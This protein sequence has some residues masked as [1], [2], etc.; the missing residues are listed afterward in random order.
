MVMRAWMVMVVVCWSGM[1]WAAEPLNSLLPHDTLGFVEFDPT[2][3]PAAGPMRGGSL[4]DLGVETMSSLGVMHGEAATITN[5]LRLAG[6]LGQKRSCVAWLGADFDLDYQTGALA[7]HEPQVVWVIDVGGRPQTVLGL[8]N[9]LL[10]DESSPETARQEIVTIRDR[11]VVSFYDTRWSSWVRLHW[12]LDGN[13]FVITLGEGAMEKYLAPR[14]AEKPS[15]LATFA[16][17]DADRPAGDQLPLRAYWG[18]DTFRRQWPDVLSMSVISSLA[19]VIGA[20]D[21]DEVMLTGRLRN[22]ALTLEWAERPH[23]SK[24]VTITPWTHDLPAG[25]PLLKL[26]PDDA[27][28]YTVLRMDWPRFYSRIA[29]LT[30]V[31]EERGADR[32]GVVEDVRKI[33]NETGVDVQ[34]DLVE[35]LGD[36][37]LIHDAPRHP[38]GLPMMVTVVAAARPGHEEAVGS[39]IEKLLSRAAAVLD[40]RATNSVLAQPLN[41][42]AG[43]EEDSWT[44]VR[45]RHNARGISYLQFGL[46]G[47]AWVWDAPCFIGS[48][49]PGALQEV[50]S[51]VRQ[52]SPNTAWFLEPAEK[53]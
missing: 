35:G 46:A 5:A 27:S 48:W 10:N 26:V 44:D 8:I 51:L 11:Q 52:A 43:G 30:D 7:A 16:L 12:M 4:F 14:P 19:G 28:L 29:D 40:R 42:A 17:A 33:K 50:R 31:I 20:R 2:G 23:G 37:V 38:L 24:Q 22:R 3:L 15:W 21:A 6:V 32:A 25:A 45:I 1:V 13:Y 34:Q 53:K 39:A 47:P 36:L 18:V 49:S 9:S 41:G